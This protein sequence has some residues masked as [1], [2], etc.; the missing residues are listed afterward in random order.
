MCEKGCTEDGGKNVFVSDF[1]A[2]RKDFNGIENWK[3]I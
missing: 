3:K 1:F 2:V